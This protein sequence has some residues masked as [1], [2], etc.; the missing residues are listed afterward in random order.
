MV[1]RVVTGQTE[2]GRAVVVAD[3][4]LEPV[5]LET[6]PGSAF[7][8]IWGSDEPLTLPS[9]GSMPRASWIPPV[10]GFRFG[11]SVIPP[12]A[13]SVPGDADAMARRIDEVRAKLPGLADA[14]EPDHP[15]MHTTDTVDVV[16]V[17][18]G[19][20][21]CELDEGRRVALRAGDCLVQNGTRHAW[22]NTSGAPCTLAITMIGVPRDG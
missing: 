10:G 13:G 14:L 3:G 20:I 22:R 12:D 11:I 19:A 18:D 16:F 9:D 15:G 8:L 5:R 1:R 17:V 2:D 7:D 21:E 4:E 6:Q